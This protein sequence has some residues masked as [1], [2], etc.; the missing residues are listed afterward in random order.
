M[1]RQL[2]PVSAALCSAFSFG[3]LFVMAA[4]AQSSN[5]SLRGTVQDQTG[6]LVPGVAIQIAEQEMGVRIKTISNEAGLYVFPVLVPGT[7]QITAEHPGMTPFEGTAVVQAQSSTSIDIVLRPS[8]TKSVVT[9]QDVTPL[10]IT[11]TASQTHTLEH[12]RIDQ[13][14]LNGRSIWNLLQTVPG[15]TN[16]TDGNL[17]VYGLRQGTH[18]V[19]L[20]GAAL[21]DYLDGGGAVARMP[22]LDS[23]QEFTVDNNA[24][25]AKFTR[26][27]TVIYLTKNGT[28]QIHGSLFETNRNNA[29]GVA[30]SRNNLTNTAP[31]LNRNE[32]GGSVG[33][34][35]WV[36]RIYN[37]KNRSF[38]FFAYEGYKLRRSTYNLYRVPTDAMRNGDFSGL[39][40]ATNTLSPIYDPWSTGSAADNWQRT[41]FIGNHISS[42]LES[43]LAKTLYS[44]IPQPNIPNANP[45]V[46]PNYSGAAPTSTDQFTWSARLDHRFSTKDQLWT[47]LTNSLSNTYQPAANG[48]PM[49][50]GFG[51]SVSTRYPNKSISSTWTH[52]FS[53]TFISETLFS[54]TRNLGSS[55]S[56]TPG[57]DY[58]S[59]LGLPNLYNQP[60]YPVINNIGVGTGNSNYVQP[61]NWKMNWY[62]YF[63]FE[64]NLTKVKGRH[65]LQFGAH[66]RYDQLT[67]LPQHQQTAGLLTFPAVA[68]GLYNPS[69]PNRTA[70]T[71]NTGNIAASFYLGL[72]NYQQQ[73]AKGKYYTR[74]NEDA[75][76]FQDN[77]KVTS[78]LTLNLGLRWQF[79]PYAKPK[80]DV[81]TSFDLNTM[82]IVLGTPLSRLYDLGAATPP[83]VNA[84]VAN[85]AKFVLPGQVGLTKRLVNNNWHDIGPHVG[86]AYQALSGRKSFVIR[87]G[88]ANTYFPLLIHGWADR[89]RINSPFTGT[90]QNYLLTSSAFAPDGLPN[91]GLINTPS[92]IAG[93]NSEN[94]LSVNDVAGIAIGDQSFQEA[95]FN[96]NQ[97]TSRVYEWNLTVEKEVLAN[98][99]LR[100]AYVGNHAAYQDS[101]L[102]LNAQTP[103]WVWYM[104]TRTQYPTGP[105]GAALSRPLDVTANGTLPYGD[106]QE[107]RKD[108]WGNSNGAQ[109]E[110]ERRFAKGFGFQIF[111]NMMN[112]F[113]AGGNGW[114]ADSQVQPLSYFL[115][116]K[117]P[118]DIHDRMKLLLYMRD[119]VIPK[120]DVHWNWIV[121]LPFG[122]G[123]PLARNA[124]GVVD[125]VIGGWQ[126]AGLGRAYSNYFTLPTGI[127][128][129]D[130]PVQFYGH[131][132]PIQDCRGGVCQ[133]GYL[134]YN[135]YI[136]AFQINQTNAA[137]KCIGI[138]GVPS[139]YQPSVSPIIPY[140][141]NYPSL[142]SKT[143]PLYGYYGTNTVW[144]PLNDGTLQQVGYGAVNPFIN[145]PVLSTWLSNWDASLFKSLSIKERAKLRVQFDF[146]N[147]FN[148]AGNNPTP[149]DNTGV[150]LKNANANPSGPRV[151]QLAARLTW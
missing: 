62:N 129:T 1:T 48:V 78:R 87:S 89:M 15:M 85:G 109:L 145:Q 42:T 24:S 66:L 74:G 97:P 151:M 93:K 146:F 113:R 69:I 111:Y 54:A 107:Y 40:D 3:T 122:K 103:S 5:G 52:S 64:D 61:I 18:D 81:F 99:L 68:T 98:T 12:T 10:V 136:P 100:V 65:E 35:I 45:L 137:G 36:P 50:N 47:R 147:V 134:L 123:K 106:I 96:P 126:V 138:C 20:D 119:I 124:H 72:A 127:Y 39:V 105:W 27:G 37:G 32:Y 11:D 21:T 121:D 141:T 26:P 77:F 114:V 75:F 91:Y 41:P 49:L 135:G 58:A 67:T 51:N 63:I 22:S 115:P 44:L 8:G 110:L 79:T 133:A 73:V 144:I 90:Y 46:T 6:A 9:V 112:A 102:N 60:S 30:R 131:K 25:S 14:P 118:S 84:L 83:L 132:Y 80:D 19:L 56:G 31:P 142:N 101:Y 28:N 150:I 104:T 76:Y 140:P 149:I 94:A 143:D 139:T 59:Q 86:F 82:S 116:G 125:A 17:H 53:P 148:I 2:L 55:F 128:P 108:G 88:F 92:V 95:Y 4:W 70:G 7:Y 57:V 71:P 120:H 34:P 43:P 33:G 130:A 38:F 13:L 16:G 23:I 117:V 29:Y